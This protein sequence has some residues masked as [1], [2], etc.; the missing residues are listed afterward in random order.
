MAKVYA[1]IG[2]RK[3]PNHILELMQVVAY[4]LAQLGW[5]LR[6][7]GAEGA[8]TAFQTGVEKF[9]EFKFPPKDYQEIY[10]PWSNPSKPFNNLLQDRERGIIVENNP[11]ADILAAQHHA[12]YSALSQG[13]KKLMKRNCFQVL[14]PQLNDPVKMIICYTVDGSIG[15]T[16]RDTGGTG[17]AIRIAFANNIPIYNLARDDHYK[18]IATWIKNCS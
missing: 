18:R 11:A 9:C 13:G 14:G 17:Q 10:I 5:K 8:D 16:S 12:V 7:G 15:E 4:N 2:S 1:G 3:C 6:S